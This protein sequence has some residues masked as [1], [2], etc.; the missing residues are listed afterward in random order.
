MIRKGWAI[1]ISVIA[2]VLLILSSLTN[3]VGYHTV[4]SSLKGGV[5]NIDDESRERIFHTIRVLANNHEIQNA[6]FEFNMIQSRLLGKDFS[7]VHHPVITDHDLEVAYKVGSFLIKLM[8]ETGV[9]LMLNRLLIR[10]GGAKV[11][12]EVIQRNASLQAE[13]SALAEL[14]SPC[15]CGET[16][17]L[18]P[19]IGLCI[20]LIIFAILNDVLFDLSY[21]LY[22]LFT[23]LYHT[24][25]FYVFLVCV[26][27]SGIFNRF[28]SVFLEISG[29][30]FYLLVDFVCID[31]YPWSLQG[32]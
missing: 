13:V 22:L 26:L 7:F 5:E 25:Y 17:R 3:V 29:T 27:L 31:P 32:W 18:F 2:I 11:L 1:G 19:P 12:S 10:S 23:D 4:Q 14:K 15:D 16:S 30:A 21:F 8:G 20:V 9:M 6:L 24:S 28:A